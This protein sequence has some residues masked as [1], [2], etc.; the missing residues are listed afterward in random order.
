VA[1]EPLLAGLRVVEIGQ[2]VAAPF[3]ATLFADQGADVVKIERPGGDPYRRDPARYAAWNRGKTSV[4]LDLTDPDD[5]ARALELVADA[6]VLI[7]NLRPGAMTRL[8]LALDE[9]RVRRTE[10]VTCSISAYGPGG[11]SRDDPGWEP[12]VHARA[13]AQQGM[14]TAARPIWL[15]FP[16]AS[17]AA[18]L[19]AVLGV[20]AALVKRETTGYG[21][22]VE[23]SLF[24]ALL[25][26]NGGPIFHRARHRPGRGPYA[27]SAHVRNERWPRRHGQLERNRAVARAV[28][29]PRPRR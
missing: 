23:T 17:V 4:E 1:A 24:E 3:A 27:G 20:G 21:Q 15:P 10:L 13:G 29:A 7:E 8:G 12:L 11:P 26:L 19:F 28:P 5:R 2:Y 6:D 22:H 25:F 9:L 16:M 14:F 18:G